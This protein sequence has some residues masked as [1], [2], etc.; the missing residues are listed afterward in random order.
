MVTLKQKVQKN[1]S[2]GQLIAALA[3]LLPLCYIGTF[4]IHDEI[5]ASNFARVSVGMQRI[6]V[7]GILGTLRYA[8]A[9]T[10]P[11]P[12]KPWKQPGCAETYVYPSWGQPFIP[13]V[14][15]VWFDAQGIAIGKYRFVSW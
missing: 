2:R 3:V 5:L 1:P 12:F 9:C 15:V 13:S 6:E 7:V 4:E 10:P 11:G 8:Q 14:W